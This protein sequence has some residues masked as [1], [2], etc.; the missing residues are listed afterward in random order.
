LKITTQFEPFTSNYGHG[1]DFGYTDCFDKGRGYAYGDFNFWIGHISGGYNMQ[2]SEECRKQVL[3]EYYN[4]N[5][6][7]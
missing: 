6:N 1:R 2:M 7:S 5:Y 4:E 3:R